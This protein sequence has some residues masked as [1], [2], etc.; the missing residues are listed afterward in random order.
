MDSRASH[1][2]DAFTQFTDGSPVALAIHGVSVTIISLSTAAVARVV[3]VIVRNSTSPRVGQTHSCS[4]FPIRE[5][6]L[7]GLFISHLWTST[8]LLISHL[9][10]FSHTLYVLPGSLCGIQTVVVSSGVLTTD[11]W[12][13]ALAAVTYL[14]IARPLGSMIPRI[15]G[16]WFGIGLWIYALAI[17]L[18]TGL[19][20]LNGAMYIGGYCDF[21]GEIWK[22]N[23]LMNLI[24]RLCVLLTIFSLYLQLHILLG[25]RRRRVKD[26]LRPK[27]EEGSQ[28]PNKPS[29]L[30]GPHARSLE[31]ETLHASFLNQNELKLWD[32][33]P[34][35]CENQT[36]VA[37]PSLITE[38]IADLISR[39]ARTLLLLFPLSYTILVIVSLSKLVYD[40]TSSKPSTA[41]H[42]VAR[43]THFLQGSLDALTYGWGGARLKQSVQRLEERRSSQ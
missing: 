24:P 6:M 23:E 12:T 7:L 13:I 4:H 40:T 16:A 43:W 2:E 22:Y 37:N 30:E 9:V 25:S 35:V 15:E 11:L 36:A 34:T 1:P 31:G 32:S 28:N 38:S 26:A 29:E 8:T 18:S 14:S 27:T 33:G 3:F 20:K 5:R 42:T 10:S 21:G 39:K 19:W 17:A 41:L